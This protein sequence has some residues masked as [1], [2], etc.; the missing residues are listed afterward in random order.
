MN[1]ADTADCMRV[2]V[3]DAWCPVRGPSGIAYANRILH[4][5]FRL[6][7]CK[8]CDLAFFTQTSH[9]SFTIDCR[10]TGRIIPS[11]FKPFQSAK[12]YVLSRLAANV[13]D[14]SA[15]SVNSFRL[16]FFI[17]LRSM[18]MNYCRRCG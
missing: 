1:Q 13:S 4:C 6:Q 9:M 5:V 7:G 16:A 14:N 2:G 3:L 17:I 10:H 12:Q 11:V 15:H 18:E 8:L